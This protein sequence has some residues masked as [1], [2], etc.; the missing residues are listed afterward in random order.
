MI[1]R[2]RT[3]QA[4]R[5]PPASAAR[6]AA[7][8]LRGVLAA[9]L[10]VTGA[11]TLDA[12]G[13]AF[14]HLTANT[15]NSFSAGTWSLR[16]LDSGFTHSCAVMANTT[17][18]CWG[19]ND[20]GQLG[21]AT[22]TNRSTPVTVVGPGGTGTFTGAAS[23]SVFRD[24]SCAVK[25]DGTVWC[26]GQNDKGQLGTNSTTDSTSPVQVL[27]AGGAGVLTGVRSMAS[28]EKQSCAVKNDGTVW[29]WGENNDGQLGDGTT[30]NRSTPVQVVGAGGVGF[31]TSVTAVGGGLDHMCAV[32]TTGALW[33]WGRNAEGQLGD[34]TTTGRSTPVQVVGPGGSGTLTSVTAVDGGQSHSCVLRSDATV[35]CW[36]RNDKG[37]LGDNSTSDRTNPGQVRGIGGTGFLTG[38]SVL[39]TGRKW[40]CAV[41]TTGNAR[42]W[43]EG[44][45]GQLGENN[46]ND[47]LVPV[48][49]QAVGGGGALAGV[50]E[51]VGGQDTGAGAVAMSCARATVTAWCWGENANGALGDGTTTQRLTPVAVLL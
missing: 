23:V 22:K 27:G 26:W 46:T 13:A 48:V 25:S 41:L 50:R 42:C 44:A 3:R 15:A 4:L 37:Q 8:A 10:L 32:R 28:G 24:F 45:G 51:I 34:N 11:T 2:L 16:T 43:G 39:G 5:R 1:R 47:R 35:W 6:R 20:Q 29:C 38:V 9:G 14:S 7:P 21:D 12:S 36:G 30:T 17:V 40:S 49:V 18:K 33:C 31:L 19:R